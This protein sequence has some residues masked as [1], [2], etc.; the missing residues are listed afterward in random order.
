M[1]TRSLNLD[2]M[3]ELAERLV[4]DPP[5]PTGQPGRDELWPVVT[6]R[7]SLFLTRGG[8]DFVDA[9]G[10]AGLNLTAAFDPRLVGTGRFS[11]S[12]LRALLYAHGLVIEDPLVMAADMYLSTP[13]ELRHIARA[14]IETAVTNLVEIEHLLD[15]DVVETYFP[16]SITKADGAAIAT[17]IEQSLTGGAESF[18]ADSVWEAFEADFIDGLNPHLQRL[19]RLVRA[20][21]R[22]PDLNI[23]RAAAADGDPR[24]VSTFIEVVGSLRRDDVLT[25]AIHAVA[26]AMADATHLGGRHDFLAS[27]PLMARLVAIG[28]S[29]RG[30]P[31]RLLELAKTDVPR[32]DD[33][34]M[35]DIVR[36]RESS[37]TL[38]RWRY[39]LTLALERA[40]ELRNSGTDD[41]EVAD[42]VRQVMA[43]ARA[44]VLGETGR[45]D[46]PRQNRRALVT[47]A[48]GM[49]GGAV[50]G[51][52]DGMPS[53]VA[54][55]TGAG[56]AGAIAALGERW[57]RTPAFLRRHY[58]VFEPRRPGQSETRSSEIT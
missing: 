21:D 7:S 52:A 29:E 13:S 26:Q 33:L 4:A 56:L 34:S 17:H 22:S 19:W 39:H 45:S 41:R 15:A 49:F 9:P 3:G 58:V 40:H 23:V 27:S 18:G 25:N 12:V 10:G 48:A 44:Q 2:A 57:T 51:T 42:A 38:D 1:A 55:A 32:L 53:V 43:E 54:G 24:L 35:A 31:A 47:F 11:G 36:I 14:G 5:V 8:S 28:C 16:S 37:E 30:A 46:L 20:G 6:A 50:G